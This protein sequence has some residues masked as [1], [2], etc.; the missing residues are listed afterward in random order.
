V[1]KLVIAFATLE[2]IAVVV[3]V[4][5]RRDADMRRLIPVVIATA[6]GLAVAAA[7]YFFLFQV[8][9]NCSGRADFACE[10]N[11]NVGMLTLL[12]LVLALGAVWTTVLIRFFDQRSQSHELQRRAD[13]ALLSAMEEVRHNLIHVALSYDHDGKF[14]DLPLVQFDETAKLLQNPIRPHLSGSV[15]RAAELIQRNC[16][17]MDRVAKAEEPFASGEPVCIGGFTNHSLKLLISAGESS[18]TGHQFL[19][20][21]GLQ[22]LHDAALTSHGLYFIFR[23]SDEELKSELAT[24]RSKGDWIIAWWNDDPPDRAKVLA[25][26]PRFN[27]LGVGHAH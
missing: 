24:I 12:G 20:Q 16:A 18:R 15:I 5:L 11:A 22:D 8:G 21:P 13:T 23:T 9:E 10:I 2:T 27:D 26:G 19:H 25:Q 1:L 6:S 14:T 7:S 4:W 17:A 3:I